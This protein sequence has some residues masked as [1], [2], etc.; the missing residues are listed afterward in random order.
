MEKIIKIILCLLFTAIVASSCYC[1]GFL[2][3]SYGYVGGYPVTV[4]GVRP[5]PPRRV[6]VS[7]PAPPRHPAPVRGMRR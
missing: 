1:D 7:R 2:Y 3:E 4:I 5:T 6:R